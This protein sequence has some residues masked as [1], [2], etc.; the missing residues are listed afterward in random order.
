MSSLLRLGSLRRM[1]STLYV[2]SQYP[3]CTTCI[4]SIASQPKNRQPPAIMQGPNLL[5]PNSLD[6]S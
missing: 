2:H 3:S 5:V 6:A 4:P 1:Q